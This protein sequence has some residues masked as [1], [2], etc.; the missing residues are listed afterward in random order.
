VPMLIG[1]PLTASALAAHAITSA[2]V[3][4]PVSSVRRTAVRV[5]CIFCICGPGT[6]PEN[7]TRSMLS[8]YPR[9]VHQAPVDACGG[10]STSERRADGEP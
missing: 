5:R 2:A 1:V 8:P 10:D 3:S 6:A 9:A 7:R 4:R